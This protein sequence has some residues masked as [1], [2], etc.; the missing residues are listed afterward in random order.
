MEVIIVE[1]VPTKT[2][3]EKLMQWTKMIFLLQLAYFVYRLT[4]V[5]NH[6]IHYMIG[7]VVCGIYVPLCGYESAKKMNHR[8]LFLFIVTQCFFSFVVLFD[9]ITVALGLSMLQ[10]MCDECYVQF[11]A[12]DECELVGSNNESV[13]INRDS[14]VY[15]EDCLNL[16]NNTEIAIYM[17]FMSCLFS[18]GCWAIVVA[19]RARKEKYVVAQIVHIAPDVECQVA[20]GDVEGAVEE[21]ADVE[22]QIVEGNVEGAVEE[23][24]AVVD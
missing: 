4:T 15:V 8:N 3:A 16:P 19:R 7:F 23:V 24:S 17:F 20:E 18:S 5:P 22:Y 12:K 1:G 11:T 6:W 21:V 13:V 10:D 2:H 9:I 14:N